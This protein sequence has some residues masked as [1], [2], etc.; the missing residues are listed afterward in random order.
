MEIPVNLL[1]P[2]IKLYFSKTV[3][4]ILAKSDSLIQATYFPISLRFDWQNP[5]FKW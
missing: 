1:V 4:I 5:L 3:A 2:F